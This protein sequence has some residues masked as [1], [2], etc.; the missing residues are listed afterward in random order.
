MDATARAFS[1]ALLAL[2]R[3]NDAT[4][5]STLAWMEQLGE[6]VNER[7]DI[8]LAEFRKALEGA[9]SRPLSSGYLSRAATVH[10]HLVA[11]FYPMSAFQQDI[12]EEIAKHPQASIYRAAL[13]VRD[14]HLND[15]QEALDALNAGQ[16]KEPAKRERAE[17]E[18]ADGEDEPARDEPAPNPLDDLARQVYEV[19][20][21]GAEAAGRPVLDWVREQAA[22][23]IVA[24]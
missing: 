5:L 1:N 2:K 12:L 16:F 6:A 21:A 8:T 10:T 19:A 7:G 11:R 14:G 13:A 24:A 23:A 20:C 15:L 18:R 3:I 17:R 22:K 9:S 4:S